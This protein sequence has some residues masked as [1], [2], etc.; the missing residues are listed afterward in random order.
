MKFRGGEF[1]TGTT[2]NFQ[3]ELT[4]LPSRVGHHH[5]WVLRLNMSK[6]HLGQ[7]AQLST[8]PRDSC[9]YGS[10]ILVKCGSSSRFDISLATLSRLP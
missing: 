9:P 5:C 10:E 3:P 1:L 8:H 7:R 4:P 6:Q 2:G